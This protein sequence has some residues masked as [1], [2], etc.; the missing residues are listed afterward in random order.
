LDKQPDPTPDEHPSQAAVRRLTLAIIAAARATAEVRAI[1]EHAHD[2][3]GAGA[4]PPASD[5]DAPDAPNA[6]AAGDKPS[7]GL[8]PTTRQAI[9]V[10]VAASLAIIIGELVSPARWFWAVIAAFVIFAGTNSWGE[11]LTKGW[12]R[13]LGT[14]LG[15]P[16]GMV[17]AT[18]VAG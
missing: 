17:V 2:G 13:M 9:Q 11:T 15:V 7:G 14:A 18:L 8:L 3:H 4:P 16:S 6:R 10:S 1:V 12:Q 5:D